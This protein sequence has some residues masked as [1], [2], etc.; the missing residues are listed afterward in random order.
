[1]PCP[2]HTHERVHS[3]AFTA[4]ARSA[5]CPRRRTRACTHTT[6]PSSPRR[7]RSSSGRSWHLCVHA[8]STCHTRERMHMCAHA[9]VCTCTCVHICIGC[10][11]GSLAVRSTDLATDRVHRAPGAKAIATHDAR[12]FALLILK[13][14][15]RARLASGAP[16]CRSEATLAARDC[17][18]GSHG[19]RGARR[20]VGALGG[21]GE[22]RCV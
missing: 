1:M 9:H 19:A 5:L 7:S 22:F 20:A 3:R 21:G 2:C 18:H 17:S 4:G 12:G 11:F 10:M 16:G 6:R 14:A 15:R 13:G 8:P